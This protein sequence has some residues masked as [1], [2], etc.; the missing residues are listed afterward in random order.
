MRKAGDWSIYLVRSK[1]FFSPIVDKTI[2]VGVIFSDQTLYL[3]TVPIS[4]TK[5]C[6]S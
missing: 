3:S 6:L 5:I 4:K 2:D 1:D